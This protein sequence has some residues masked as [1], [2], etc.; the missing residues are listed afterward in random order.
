MDL[1]CEMILDEY[2]ENLKTYAKIEELVS[3]ELNRYVKDFGVVVNSVETRIK[4]LESLTGKL[5]IKGSKYSTIRDITDIVG[6][7]IV[8]FYSDQVDKFAAKIESNF[9]IDWDNSIDKRKMHN[10]DQ[11]GYMSLHYICTI[12]KEMY[13]D[14]N[15]PN[16]N[17]FKFEIQLRSILQ[18]TWASIHHDTGYKNDIEVPKE[19]LRALNRLSGLLELADDAFCNIRNGLDDYRRRVKQ[20]VKN[21]K[22][23]DVELNGDSFNAYIENGGFE[24]LN[25]RISTINN[26]EIEKVSL[27]EFLKVFKSLQF[28]TLK[29][30]DQFVRNYSD[31]AYDFAVR[32][33][34]GKDLDII[35]SATGPLTLSVV[36]ILSK[37]MGEV[38]VKILLDTIYGKRKSNVHMAHT[39]TSIGK[40]MGL[41]VTD[42]ENAQ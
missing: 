5:E 40:S 22:F 4:T 42:D 35:T 14:P 23:D 21:G 18:H 10:I 24:T 17:E 29:D 33:F 16:I 32:Q 25:H 37:D 31:L 1:H 20:V 36:Y 41:V 27:R 8:T 34:S 38:V 9:I 28:K 39:L 11:F 30:L 13:E 2:K 19:Y 7:R 6:G 26:M 3:K 15:D 12:P